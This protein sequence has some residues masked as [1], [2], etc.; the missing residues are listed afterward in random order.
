MDFYLFIIFS[1]N[2]HTGYNI[3]ERSKLTKTYIILFFT[4]N[5]IDISTS[6]HTIDVDVIFRENSDQILTNL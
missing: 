6:F 3:R 2:M 5:F 4:Q 1:K